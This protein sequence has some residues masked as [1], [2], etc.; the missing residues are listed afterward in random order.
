[1]RAHAPTPARPLLFLCC[2]RRIGHCRIGRKGRPHPHTRAH[3]IGAA[4]CPSSRPVEPA[5]TRTHTRN[6]GRAPPPPGRPKRLRRP[7]K[8]PP[9]RRAQFFIFS[10]VASFFKNIRRPPSA[11]KKGAAFS[12]LPAPS[13]RI[14]PKPA[15]AASFSKGPSSLL[16]PLPLSYVLPRP[17]LPAP[18]TRPA[19]PP[20]CSRFSRPPLLPFKAASA[21]SSLSGRAS[22]LL[23]FCS[24]A[25]PLAPPLAFPP[26]P[27]V[28]FRHF[29]TPSFPACSSVFHRFPPPL[30][31]PLPTRSAISPSR[32]PR[33]TKKRAH[34]SFPMRAPVFSLGSAP[35]VGPG[36]WLPHSGALLPALQPQASAAHGARAA[37]GIGLLDGGIVLG[38]RL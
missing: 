21:S 15:R 38:Q 3:A 37:R 9:G 8:S 11:A 26:S 5:H 33:R 7:P 36:S 30:R 1:M 34:A 28:S 17:V 13:R 32:F 27:A 19:A 23:P 25:A 2:A 12:F 24:P 18:G 20:A 4:F 6:C 29:S 35:R 10:I 14:S 31:R 22:S 16:C